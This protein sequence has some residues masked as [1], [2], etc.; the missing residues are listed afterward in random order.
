[1]LN[2]IPIHI[3][4]RMGSV[5][6][7]QVE[8]PPETYLQQAETALTVA[9]KKAVDWIAYHPELVRFTEENL[10]ILGSLKN[11]ITQ[12]Q[13]SLAYQP[14]VCLRTGAV[15]G[16][17]ALIRWNHPQRG[18]L[19]PEA[20]IPRIEQST[21]IQI[22]TEFVLE[23]AIRQMA[24]W[25]R[26]DLILPVAVNISTRNLLQPGFTDLVASLLDQHGIDGASLE[27]E[28]TEGALMMDMERSIA[29][30][31][32]MS[33]LNIIISIDDFGTGYSSLQYLHRLPISLIKIDQ[34]FVHR[35]PADKGAVSI[36]EAAVMLAHRMGIK[37]IA[38][39]VEHPAVHGFLADIG[40]D[41]AQGF[42][43]SPPLPAQAFADWHRQC[44]GRF[45]LATAP[46]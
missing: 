45:S 26:H 13:L 15:H 17:E 29:E 9:Q 21:L 34:S 6:F 3:D 39:G 32:R 2:G 42:L 24:Q 44:S 1:L 33:E 37:V 41:M 19:P 27:L 22:I 11:A 20:F 4:T 25:L 43:I 31:A 23:Q 18:P 46:S 30:L 5:A 8:L 36:V 35:L 14:K 16:A 38:E 12:G 7:N 28:I 10:A 40:C